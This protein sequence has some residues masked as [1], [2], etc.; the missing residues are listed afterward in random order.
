MLFENVE[1]PWFQVAALSASPSYSIPLLEDVLDRFAGHLAFTSIVRQ[2][3]GVVA[4]SESPDRVREFFTKS[5]PELS[6]KL[7]GWEASALA[8]LAEGLR[9]RHD[10]MSLQNEGDKL[11]R[12]YFEHP[13]PE[14]R[15]AT[16]ELI[17]VAGI[18]DAQKQR[19]I[20]I[21]EGIAG[22]KSRTSDKRSEAIAFL[23]VG[24]AANHL[25]LLR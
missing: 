14:L 24:D 13:S 4:A 7:L 19:A 9:R 25:P 18:G 5:T 21:A 16:L 8:G 10:T 6:R 1:D 2:L 17:R 20:E 3:M 22:D 12:L 11:I 15:K 23:G